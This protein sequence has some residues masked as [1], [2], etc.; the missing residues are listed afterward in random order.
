MASFL[1]S[2]PRI[3]FAAF[4]LWLSTL[5]L[6]PIANAATPKNAN[7]QVTC[8][9]KKLGYEEALFLYLQKPQGQIQ[10]GGIITLYEDAK[11]KV[12]AKGSENWIYVRVIDTNSLAEKD[13]EGWMV[14]NS[15][16]CTSNVAQV[17]PATCQVT[18]LKS[19][20]LALRITAGGKS[21]AGLD[22][23]NNVTL[24]Q[25]HIVSLQDPPT[26]WV[27]VRV[28]NTSNT[29]VMGREGWISSQYIDCYSNQSNDAINYP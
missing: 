6:L 7:R 1:K 10:G 18:G 8:Q 21:T 2:L 5:N 29:R 9:A 27:N 12:L 3:S 14:S 20:Q 23:G 15:L 19:G 4:Y 17:K 11:L 25:P 26:P 28:T 16:K 22:N 24:L 13:L